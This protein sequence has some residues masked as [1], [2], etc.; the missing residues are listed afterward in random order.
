ML[1]LWKKIKLLYITSL[2]LVLKLAASLQ[3]E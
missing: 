3:T 2:K 1:N